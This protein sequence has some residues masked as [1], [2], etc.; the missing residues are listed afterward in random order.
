[1][2]TKSDYEKLYMIMDE[3]P[4]KKE[5]LSLDENAFSKEELFFKAYHESITG[6]YNWAWMWERLETFY[7]EGEF[8]EISGVT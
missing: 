3:S 2:F 7:L 5:L 6:Y 8:H 4:E 1:M